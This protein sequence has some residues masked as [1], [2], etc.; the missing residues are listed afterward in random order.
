M[1]QYA[2][3][4]KAFE[5]ILTNYYNHNMLTF[6]RLFCLHFLLDLIM[7]LFLI[8][9]LYKMVVIIFFEMW[10][11]IKTHHC[12][13][14]IAAPFKLLNYISWKA[15]LEGLAKFRKVTRVR[16]ISPKIRGF[17][18]NFPN[19]SNKN[20]PSP[21]FIQACWLLMSQSICNESKLSEI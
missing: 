20:G 17:Q 2:K 21:F 8:L 10:K 13:K 18:G 12:N 16:E 14:K 15:L 5:T 4:K 6:F 1:R 3:K 9:F 11:E 7:Q 19:L